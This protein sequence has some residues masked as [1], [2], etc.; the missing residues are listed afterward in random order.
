[1]DADNRAA[2]ERLRPRGADTP[3]VRL[4]D[5]VSGAGPADVPDPYY[6]GDFEATLD[7]I[8]AGCRGLLQTLAPR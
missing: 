6:T 4:L 8:E 3:V 1:M 7:L 2:V 5:H